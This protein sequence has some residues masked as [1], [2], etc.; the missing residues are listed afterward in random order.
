MKRSIRDR[1]VNINDEW[2]T[3]KEHVEFIFNNYL[4]NEDFTDKI[5]YCPADSDESE[6]VKYL[7]ANKLM[8]KYK[9]WRGGQDDKK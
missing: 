8:L 1:Q 7:K 4:G 5:I 9:K 3:T 6:F 2:Y